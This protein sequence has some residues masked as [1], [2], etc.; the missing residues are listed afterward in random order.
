MRTEQLLYEVKKFLTCA[1]DDT[2]S[3]SHC[4]LAEVA[5]SKTIKICPNQC[6]DL[7]RFLFTGFF[8]NKKRPGT[9]F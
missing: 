2:F 1:L 4:F 9:S 3:R 6:T 7:L 5:F 8:E